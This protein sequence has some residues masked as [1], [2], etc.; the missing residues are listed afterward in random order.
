MEVGSYITSTFSQDIAD[1]IRRLGVQVDLFW[2]E[3][4]LLYDNIFLPPNPKI[5][6]IGSGPGHYV[7]KLSSLF[8]NASFLSLEY[9]KTFCRF[10]HELFEGDLSSRVEVINGD[11]NKID[12]L[13]E[14][15][16]VVSRM[17]LEHLPD[18][19]VVFDKM[20]SFVKNGGSLLLLDNDFSNHL[21]TDPRVDELDDLYQA[22]CA[23]R[24][25]Q[26]GNPYIGR[27]LPKYFKLA[28]YDAIHF[29]TITAHTCKIDKALFMGAESSAI[30][31][32]LVK[33]GYLDNAVFKRLIINW[34]KMAYDPENIMLREIYCAYG[35]KI[36]STSSI[37]HSVT[38]ST[39][40]TPLQEKKHN[41]VLDAGDIVLP[42]TKREKQIAKIWCELLDIEQISANVSFFDIGGESYLIPLIVD[43]LQSKHQIDIEITDIFEYPTISSLATF[44]D[45]DDEQDTLKTTAEKAKRQRSVLGQD[46]K[47]NPFARLKKK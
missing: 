12:G 19:E 13:G 43:M 22:Y 34:S 37:K 47:T 35:T 17:V 23:M 32:T 33:E 46:Q 1:E 38:T 21:R 42:T 20:S 45:G 36:A 40:V 18:Q 15:D 16:L 3:E 11:I 39:S 30:G 6:E 44:V 31:L 2:E 27:E 25:T 7:K 26:G 10:Q 5:L 24:L 4:K 14:F 9:D 29:K 41:V 8:S 28:G